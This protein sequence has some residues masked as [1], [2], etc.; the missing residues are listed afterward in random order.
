MR[1]KMTGGKPG[2]SSL[3][4]ASLASKS[5]GVDASAITPRTLPHSVYGGRLP[6]CD[7]SPRTCAPAAVRRRFASPRPPRA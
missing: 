7:A 2:H 4:S 5:V 6:S 3:P 1:T